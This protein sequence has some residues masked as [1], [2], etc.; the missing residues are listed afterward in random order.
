MG[1]GA[2]G[3]ILFLLIALEAPRLYSGKYPEM[4]AFRMGYSGMA[5]FMMA[6]VGT[7]ALILIVKNLPQSKLIRNISSGTF[8]V[9]ALHF[10]IL[11]ILE[12]NHVFVSDI[13]KL[14][15]L[16]VVMMICYPII[17]FAEKRCAILLGKK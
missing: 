16:A 1:G 12:L 9:L 3:A 2:I 7:I 17:L 14:S 6:F 10:Q 8:L 5:Y 4:Y 15:S 13:T 11:R